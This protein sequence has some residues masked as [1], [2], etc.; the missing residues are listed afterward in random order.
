[1][2]KETE[3]KL[4]AGKPGPGRPKGSANKTTAIIKDAI[5]AV[6][7]DLQDSVEDAD[8]ANAHFLK[9][10]KDNATEFYKL[11]SK[12]I[13]IQVGGDPDNPVIHEIK[14]TIVRP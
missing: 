4:F 1:V 12:L 5:V 9:W 6:Y 3:K 13:P 2:V 11:A 8:K 14:R 10:A 7:A